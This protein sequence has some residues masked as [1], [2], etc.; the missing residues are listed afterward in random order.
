VRFTA[1]GAA[2]FV[3]GAA[4]GYVLTRAAFVFLGPLAAVVA[5]ALLVL[6]AFVGRRRRG[7]AVAVGLPAGAALSAVVLSL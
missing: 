6:V 3:A 2:L 5:V 4:A 7:G 1:A